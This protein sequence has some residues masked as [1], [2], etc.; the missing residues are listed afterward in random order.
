VA[1]VLEGLCAVL[2]GYV[3]EDLLTTTGDFESVLNLMSV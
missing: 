1:D 3:E 2:A